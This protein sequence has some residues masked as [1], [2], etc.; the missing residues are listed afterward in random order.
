MAI[1]QDPSHG[2]GHGMLS[3]IDATKT[4]DVT[5]T[6]KLW[7]FDQIDRSLSTVA[8]ADG[9]LYVGDISGKLH[10]LDPET[11]KTY[12][13]YDTQSEIWGSTLVADGKVYL[14]T[15]KGLW[16]SRPVPPRTPSGPGAAGLARV[17]HAGGRRRRVVRQLAALFV[18]R[19]K[20]DVRHGRRPAP[21]PTPPLRPAGHPSAAAWHGR[22]ALLECG[23]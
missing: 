17:V 22:A 3:C 14:G 18:G 9:L 8:I 23:D 16:Y 1:G 11:G 19:A 20:P 21:A 6:G 15:K 13:V 5:K 12:W 10:C 7:T 4:G 2:R